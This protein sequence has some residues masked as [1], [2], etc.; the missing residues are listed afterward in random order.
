MGMFQSKMPKGVLLWAPWRAVAILIAAFAAV[1]TASA[2]N[3]NITI[4]SSQ[5]FQVIDGFGVNANHRSFTNN[6]ITPVLDSLIDQAGMTLFRVVYDNSDWEATN[7]NS[8][9]SVMNWSYYN[10]IYSGP[11]FQKMWDMM[12]YLNKKGITNGV[13]PNFQGFA[14]T[15]M[16]GL[17]LTPG[18]EDEWAEM[19]ASALIYARKTNNLQFSLVGPNNEP[20]LPGSGIGIA[21][22]PQYALTLHKLAQKLDAN[23]MSDIRFVGPDLSDGGTNWFPDVMADPLV[24]S[25]LAHFGVHSYSDYGTWSHGVDDYIK[26]SPYPNSTF[27]MTEFNVWCDTCQ[28]SISGTNS[29]DYAFGTAEY[30]LY[31]LANNATAGLVWEAY[32][33][34]YYNNFDSNMHWSYWGL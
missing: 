20:N 26:Q 28:A 15:W 4:D 18:F 21:D 1:M 32:D 14:P 22:G 25:K 16:G 5:Q 19:I 11:D 24:M 29:W 3:F 17:S 30:L 33:S 6:E 9:S 10:S 2:A 23:G 13:M 31:H 8:N 12:A 27:W 34:H 7:D